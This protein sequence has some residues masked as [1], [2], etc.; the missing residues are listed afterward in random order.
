MSAPVHCAP[1]RVFWICTVDGTLPIL[2]RGPQGGMR[3]HQ[4][5]VDEFWLG[6]AELQRLDETLDHCACVG[7]YLLPIQG[8]YILEDVKAFV[9][10]H[11]L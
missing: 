11:L 1:R 5:D 10:D 3:V 8:P 7:L 6:I 9:A 2:R 4:V